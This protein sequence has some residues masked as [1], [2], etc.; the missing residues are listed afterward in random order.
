MSEQKLL[1]QL[2]GL[3][4]RVGVDPV[5]VTTPGDVNARYV[6]GYPYADILVNDGRLSVR[7]VDYADVHPGEQVVVLVYRNPR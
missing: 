4:E 3:V 1:V 6:G 5:E 7:L 2:T